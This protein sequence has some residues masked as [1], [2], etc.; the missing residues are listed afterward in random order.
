MKFDEVLDTHRRFKNAEVSKKP[1]VYVAGKMRFQP[2][3]NFPAFFEA[4]AELRAQG[5]EVFNPARQDIENGFDPK[6]M[7]GHED[8]DELGFDLREALGGDVVWIALRADAI[9]MLE[10]WSKSSG[11]TAEHALARALGL[12]ILGAAA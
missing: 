4:E 6:G 9:Y 1:H 8:L 5:F 3:F 10:G 11:A 7:T 2:E 12:T